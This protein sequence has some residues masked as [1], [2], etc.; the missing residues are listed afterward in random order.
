MEVTAYLPVYQLVGRTT[1]CTWALILESL[2]RRRQWATASTPASV[3]AR[4]N[5]VHKGAGSSSL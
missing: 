3:I 4:C 2:D 1:L 5:G